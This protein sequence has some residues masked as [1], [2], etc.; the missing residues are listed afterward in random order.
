MQTLGSSAA[1][2]CGRLG[3]RKGD[4][5]A[6]CALFS[7]GCLPEARWQSV[8]TLFFWAIILISENALRKA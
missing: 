3:M 4:S 1:V 8:A 7:A 2:L 6:A 5:A